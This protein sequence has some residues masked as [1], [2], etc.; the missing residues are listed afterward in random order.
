MNLFNCS[1]LLLAPVLKDALSPGP[2]RCLESM[3]S[4]LLFPGQTDDF[5]DDRS[6]ASLNE[7]LNGLTCRRS[8]I[9]QDEKSLES[10]KESRLVNCRICSPR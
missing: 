2:S 3:K 8:L 1:V 7:C 9:M 10:I 5:C 4:E 6:C